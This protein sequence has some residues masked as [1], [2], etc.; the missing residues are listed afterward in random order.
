MICPLDSYCISCHRVCIVQ[1]RRW[2]AREGPLYCTAGCRTLTPCTTSKQL[3]SVYSCRFKQS[4]TKP[5]PLKNDHTSAPLFICLFEVPSCW[6]RLEPSKGGANWTLILVWAPEMSA[7][8]SQVPVQFVL[9]LC[10]F[11]LR[12]HHHHILQAADSGPSHTKRIPGIFL[13]NDSWRVIWKGQVLSIIREP[14]LSGVVTRPHSRRVKQALSM[15]TLAQL[16]RKSGKRLCL[17]SD[18]GVHYQ[19]NAWSGKRLIC[20]CTA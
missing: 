12:L 17:R 18:S 16:K 1:F 11:C 6:D 4:F 9:F 15:L 10:S 3:S 8:K 2:R 14:S 13:P 5:I 7:G 19:F 20:L